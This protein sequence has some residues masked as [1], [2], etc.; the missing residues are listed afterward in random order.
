[1]STACCSVICFRFFWCFTAVIGILFAYSV[2]ANPTSVRS[3]RVA[4]LEGTIGL[5][6]TL[7]SLLSGYTRQQLGFTWV[8]IIITVMHVLCILY[9]LFFVKDLPLDSLSEE[10]GER[11]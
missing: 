4:L 1:M 6:A 9:I 11:S 3:E 8:F 2:K 7:G 5:G 10:S